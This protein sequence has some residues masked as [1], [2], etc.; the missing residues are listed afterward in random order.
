MICYNCKT[1]LVR[2]PQSFF[3][4]A[5]TEPDTAIICPECGAFG[6]YEEVVKNGQG[7]SL[8]PLPPDELTNL[9]KKLGIV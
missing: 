8:G 6:W 7:L 9:R 2:V 5:E 3:R 4:I 1:Y